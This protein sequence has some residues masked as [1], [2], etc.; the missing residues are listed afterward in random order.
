LKII[1]RFFTVPLSYHNPSGEK[2]QIFARSAIPNKENDD[3]AAGEKL[4]ICL[5]LQGGPGFEC[6]PP[7]SHP[8][9]EWF[10]KKGYQMLYLDQRG[11]GLS[12]PIDAEILTN[13]RSVEEQGKRLKEFRAD[14]IVR[15]CE[16]VRQALLGGKEKEEERKWTV[17]G[18]SFGGFCAVTYLSFYP[19]GLKEGAR[20]PPF[21][22][23]G[24]NLCKDS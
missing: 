18:Q 1:D 13:G 23:A 7:K 22:A 5:Y 16:A 6:S 10:F 20:A 4:P 24:Y 12:T 3:G 11:T 17:I 14:N 9:T 19:E 21:F 8:L 15:D 2:I